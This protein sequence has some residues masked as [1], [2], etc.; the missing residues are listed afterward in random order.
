METL[1][2]GLFIVVIIFALLSVFVFAQNETDQTI[3]TPCAS[4]DSHTYT[5]SDGTIISCQN[6]IWALASYVDETT[7]EENATQE[8]TEV[9]P[10]VIL[11]GDALSY[12]WLENVSH[13][14][15]KFDEMVFSAIALN[16][17]GKDIGDL[18]GR[19]IAEED[20]EKGCWIKDKCDV[21]STALGLMSLYISNNK[22]DKEKEWLLGSLT[23][24]LKTGQWILEIESTVN[25]TCSLK[26][27]VGG[28]PVTKN[29]EIRQDNTVWDDKGNPAIGKYY[30]DIGKDLSSSLLETSGS[31]I[32]VD[33]SQITGNVIM[34]VIYKEGSNYFILESVPSSTY[35]VVL[36][37]GCFANVNGGK[38][39]D[40]E[41]SLYASWVLTEMGNEL[42]GLGVQAYLESELDNNDLH[43]AM[44][45]R[46]L[47]KAYDVKD[48]Y[49]KL[50]QENQRNDGAWSAG[51]IFV[52]S[53]SLYSVRGAPDY[54]KVVELATDYLQRSRKAD[55]SWNQDVKDTSMALI[56]LDG[57]INSAGT[58]N[59][60][61]TEINGDPTSPGTSVE[62]G[63]LMCSNTL[64]DDND[65]DVDCD[66]LDCYF[67]SPCSDIDIADLGGDDN[68]EF[69]ICD[70]LVDNDNDGWM[71]CGDADCLLE[72]YCTQ[73]CKNGK[74]DA[75]EEGIDC[76][77][78][79]VT[80]CTAQK[81]LGESCTS[82]WD[83]TGS[84][85][86][87]TATSICVEST[88]AGGKGVE[89]AC[90]DGKDEDNDGKIDCEDPDCIMDSVCKGTSATTS[91]N[92]DS[93]CGS[94]KECK[95]GTCVVKTGGMSST[96]IVIIIVIVVLLIGGGVFFY[97]QYVKTGK[98]SFGKKP[99][100]TF[101][102]FKKS[103]DFKPVTPGKPA[104]SRPAFKPMSKPAGKSQAEIDL[105][106]SIKE[107]EDLLKK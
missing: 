36:G 38:N 15:L 20:Q 16:N 102:D 13:S 57:N 61:P 65:G 33:C 105:D 14:P 24:G 86:C 22:Y 28:N 35:Q 58:I 55:G 48:R 23:S 68:L 97:L 47:Q 25:G 95:G 90:A 6:G 2:K 87:D 71:D 50:I 60:S 98:F 70:D 104:A 88:T 4:F 49:L 80:D 100:N 64:D 59:P 83:C 75:G 91:C 62:S 92:Q 45:V 9:T 72:D 99:K 8:E 34:T 54:T 42:K 67:T 40:Y 82:S 29:F 39:C 63:E 84:L 93:E 17:E 76:G 77:G 30:L 96:V 89:L 3:G 43:R 85:I 56:S 1:K 53:F 31:V 7:E 69:E 101:D 106:K 41:S 78:N 5:L 81:E 18:I 32:D 52:T 27:T 103:F 10:A 73:L 44:L 21:K 11:E 26:Y 51:N 107:A 79:C 94:G 37:N 19:I 12:A 74:Q 46:I 66:D